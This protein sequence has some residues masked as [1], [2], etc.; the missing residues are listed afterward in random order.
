MLEVAF[1]PT[2]KSSELPLSLSRFSTQFCL[3]RHILFKTRLSVR[4]L[5]ELPCQFGTHSNN[6][7]SQGPANKGHPLA[8]IFG[9]DG[10]NCIY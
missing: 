7:L 1:A 10:Q 8:E 3:Q 5:S 9:H 6:E 4:V 2:M